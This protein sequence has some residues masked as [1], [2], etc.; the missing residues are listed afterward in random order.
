M[1]NKVIRKR[2]NDPRFHFAINCASISCPPLHNSPY[3]GDTLENQLNQVTNNFINSEEGIQFNRNM[4]LV[5]ISAIF[6]WYD[7]D[8]TES[9]G[10]IPFINQHRNKEIPLDTFINYLPYNWTLNQNL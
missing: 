10:V 5:Y 2:F 3:I 6:D 4:N 8:F 7:E 1:E 9:G